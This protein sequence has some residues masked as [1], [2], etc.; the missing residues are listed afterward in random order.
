MAVKGLPWKVYSA[1]PREYVAATRDPENAG[2]LVAALGTGTQ[3]KFEHHTPVWTEGEEE[4]SAADSYDHVAETCLARV[5]AMRTAAKA[6][7]DA[8]QRRVPAGYVACI[9]YDDGSQFGAVVPNSGRDTL[10]QAETLMRLLKD[11]Y[12]RM[13]AVRTTKTEYDAMQAAQAKRGAL[14]QR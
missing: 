10:E 8:D 1:V 4:Q 6:R 7:F 13:R 11:V 3:I 12:T 9:K 14:V 5:A 2:I